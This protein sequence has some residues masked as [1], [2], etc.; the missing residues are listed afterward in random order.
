MTTG[1]NN[2]N[3]RDLQVIN[4]TINKDNTNKIH[5]NIHTS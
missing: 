2:A 5:D 3:N 4:N 1:V